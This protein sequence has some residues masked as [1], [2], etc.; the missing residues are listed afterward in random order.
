MAKPKLFYVK[1]EQ[2][3][4]KQV[5]ELRSIAEHHHVP[6]NFDYIVVGIHSDNTTV[7]GYTFQPSLKGMVH[8]TFDDIYT[9]HYLA[10]L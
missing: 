8:S 6:K 9:Q 4:E 1:R 3:T 7:I 5:D 2:V 10:R